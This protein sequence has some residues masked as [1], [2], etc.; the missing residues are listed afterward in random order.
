MKTDFLIDKE[1]VGLNFFTSQQG[2]ALVR[3]YFKNSPCMLTDTEGASFSPDGFSF[4]VPEACLK[5]ATDPNKLAFAFP[6]ENKNKEPWCINFLATEGHR[7]AQGVYVVDKEEKHVV[8]A[9]SVVEAFEAA[10]R[11]LQ[12]LKEEFSHDE[13][14]AAPPTLD[15]VTCD[16]TAEEIEF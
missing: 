14:E 3:V 11:R 4:I 9:H 16:Y 15:A 12:E 6:T 10:E 7:N 1:R 13:A 2:K 5:L 8:E